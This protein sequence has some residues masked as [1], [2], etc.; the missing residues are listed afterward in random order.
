MCIQVVLRKELTM[1]NFFEMK[2]LVL[3][4]MWTIPLLILGAL[5][6]YRIYLIWQ[7]WKACDEEELEKGGEK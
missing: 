7:L 6:L 4:L 5:L 1:I 2:I 3:K